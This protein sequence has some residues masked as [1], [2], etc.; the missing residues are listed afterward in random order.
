MRTREA[1]HRT[2]QIE[3]ER[4]SYRAAQFRASR[5]DCIDKVRCAPRRIDMQDARRPCEEQLLIARDHTELNESH[6]RASV[7]ARRV[8]R[9]S[10]RIQSRRRLWQTSQ[11]NRLAQC[12]IARRFAEVCPRRRF[13]ANPAIAITAAI[14]ILGENSLLT[15]APLQLPSHDCFI[16]FAMP[17]PKTFGAT[18]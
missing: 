12:E 1:L 14:Q 13:R 18:C 9:M 8:I 7:F 2:L 4:C 11:K 6:E 15:P 5:H 16:K 10:P 17:T 3:I